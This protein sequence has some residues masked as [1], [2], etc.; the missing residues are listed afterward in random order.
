MRFLKRLHNTPKDVPFFQDDNNRL[1]P[2]IIPVMVFLAAIFLFTSISLNS[3]A[4]ERAGDFSDSFSVHVPFSVDN[5][6]A[7]AER[8]VGLLTKMEDIKNA[9]IVDEQEVKRMI[10]P[11][12]GG[13]V[14]DALPLPVIV[15]ATLDAEST[16]LTER[17]DVLIAEIRKIS[18]QAEI[19]DNKRWVEQYGQFIGLLRIVLFIIAM[20]V[21]ATTATTIVLATKTGL[22][23]HYNVIMLLHSMG[24]KDRYIA[25]QFEKNALLLTLR[26][27][28][29]GTALAL[30]CFWLIGHI[31]QATEAS[32]LPALEVT[33]VEL[34]LALCIPAVTSLLAFFVSRRT[35]HAMLAGVH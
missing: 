3:S 30:L 13:T 22:K 5:P 33:V 34:V 26:G 25:A 28:A 32:L 6:K 1:L 20:V 35:V 27:A 14:I 12:L 29:L 18:P 7:Q 9:S 21:L 11:W 31:A 15:E 4:V 2:Y 8:L 19:E 10:E 16:L 24:A 23:L 17:K